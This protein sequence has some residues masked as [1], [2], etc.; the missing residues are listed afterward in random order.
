[1]SKRLIAVI[2]F[3]VAIS[4]GGLFY[5]ISKRTALTPE[6]LFES[7]KKYYDQKKY[8]EAAIQFLNTLRKNPRHRDGRLLLARTYVAGGDLADAMRQLQALLEYYPDDSAAN[9]ELGNIYLVGGRTNPDYFRLAQESAQKVL[10][11]E[12]N[13]VDALI[14]SGAASGGLK[15]F[16]ASVDTLEKATS[17][18]PTNSRALINLGAAQALQQNF[19]DAEQSFL[20]ARDK[21]PKEARSALSLAQYYLTTRQTDKAEA[22]SKMLLPQ[23]RQTGRPIFKRWISTLAQAVSVTPSAFCKTPRPTAR[24]IHLLR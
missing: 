10:A 15:D 21:N 8:S 14:L 3:I 5:Y 23:I 13:N 7:G 9:L 20:K 16:D 22:H 11:K 24:I 19:S 4:A 6:A 12:P 2:G 17:L 1:M 18:D